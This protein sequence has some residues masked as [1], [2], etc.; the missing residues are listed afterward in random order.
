[1]IWNILEGICKCYANY[2]DYT[3]VLG[4]YRFWYLVEVGD[5]IEPVF[6]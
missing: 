1:M 5:V 3:K 6:L 2:T 4:H